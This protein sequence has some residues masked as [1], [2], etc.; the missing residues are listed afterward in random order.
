MEPA[1]SRTVALQDRREQE[2]PDARRRLR[3]ALH[4]EVLRDVEVHHQHH[5]ARHDI[6]A[7]APAAADASAELDLDA[8]LCAARDTQRLR[9]AAVGER[10]AVLQRERRA[11]HHHAQLA[12]R[13]GLDERRAELGRAPFCSRSRS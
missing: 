7:G 2:A 3:V 1:T 9:R 8:A 12:V 6:E 5:L 10:V 13:P 11:L 4:D